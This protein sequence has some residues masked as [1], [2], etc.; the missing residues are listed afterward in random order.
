MDEEIAGS[1]GEGGGM[2]G[3]DALYV[4]Q[5]LGAF[6]IKGK[7][8][9]TVYA[10]RVAPLLALDSGQGD[11][12]LSAATHLEEINSAACRGTIRAHVVSHSNL[13]S[14]STSST[15]TSSTALHGMSW[16]SAS[17]RTSE[18]S[19]KRLWQ[20]E[21]RQ[22]DQIVLGNVTGEC[23]L[24]GG[25][26]LVL[27]SGSFMQQH[28][29]KLAWSK[30]SLTL[31]NRSQQANTLNLFKFSRDLDFLFLF[32]SNT[33]FAPRDRWRKL[34]RKFAVSFEKGARNYL[35]MRT[36]NTSF[37]SIFEIFV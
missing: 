19:F 34:V 36:E 26:T 25:L 27:P 13:G 35:F 8:V 14:D 37:F 11:V 4:M 31:R 33:L 23:K 9:Q 5:D 30:S 24:P 21:V 22:N 3:Q 18:K 28:A 17:S 2:I 7:G 1:K 20:P 10:A 12:Q 6:D 32:L 16:K 15:G 29:Q